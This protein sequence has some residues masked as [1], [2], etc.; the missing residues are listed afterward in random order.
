MIED[1][2]PRIKNFL[3]GASCLALGMCAGA[4]MER[5]SAKSPSVGGSPEPVL[6]EAKAEEMIREGRRVWAEPAEASRKP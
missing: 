2:S 5:E 3:A 1:L 4:A 6:N